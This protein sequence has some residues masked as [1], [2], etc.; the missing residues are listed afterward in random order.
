MTANGW[1]QIGLFFALILLIAHPL[2]VYMANVFERR[3]T[4]LDPILGPVERAIYRL[5]GVDSEI[6]MRWTT[7][8][9]AMLLFSVVSMLALYLIERVQFWLPLNPQHLPGVPAVQA[10]NTA[11]AF[12]SNTDWQSYVPETT[13]SYLTQ[14]TG[15]GYNNFTSSAVAIALAIAFVRGLCRKEQNTL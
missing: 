12:T 10:F 1:F 9:I 13:M 3:K 11:A 2:G 5:T 4:F 15:L 7:Y 6:E 8:A 14:M